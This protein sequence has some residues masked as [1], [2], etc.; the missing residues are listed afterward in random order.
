M[1]SV[2]GGRREEILETAARLFAS[3]GL[4]TSLREIAEACG[5]LPGSLYHHFDSK[6]AIIIELVHRYRDDLDRVAKEALN[7]REQPP[8]PVEDRL[9]DL[10]RA[11]AAC[12]LRNRAALLLTLYEPPS[13]LGDQLAQLGQEA[14]AKL[15]AAMEETLRDGQSEG[16]IRKTIDLRLFADRLCQSMLH[17]GVGVSHLTPGAQFVPEMRMAIQLHGIGVHTPP[18][19]ELDRSQALRVARDHIATWEDERDDDD[20]TARPSRRGARRS[21]AD[22]DLSRR[23]CATSASHQASAS[24]PSTAHFTPKTSCSSPS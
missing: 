11:V 8:R 15:Q 22:A 9:M 17:V 2:E 5:I 4:R 19:A 12:A 13:V 14:P 16:E 23:R 20:R 21:S 18:N 10:G 24:G 6:E 1:M 7:A 3:S